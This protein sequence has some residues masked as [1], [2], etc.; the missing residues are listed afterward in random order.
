M[1][2]RTRSAYAGSTNILLTGEALNP[3]EHISYL[4]TT[5]PWFGR[6]NVKPFFQRR[7]HGA[8]TTKGALRR[9]GTMSDEEWQVGGQQSWIVLRKRSKSQVCDGK[10]KPVCPVWGYKKLEFGLTAAS[11]WQSVVLR[12]RLVIMSHVSTALSTEHFWLNA[13]R[14]ELPNLFLRSERRPGNSLRWSHNSSV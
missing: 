10:H 5:C 13:L 14:C 9:N 1:T 11:H 2:W 6:M 12:R 8:G 3:Y 4:C 7:S